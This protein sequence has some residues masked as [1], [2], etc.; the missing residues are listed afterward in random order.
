MSFGEPYHYR[1]NSI[2]IKDVDVVGL[3]VQ[4]DIYENIF[5]GGI[6]GS[7]SMLETDAAKF[8]EDNEIKFIEEITFEFTNSLDQT[9]EFN[10][11]INGYKDNVVI[12]NKRL[13]TLD[14]VSKGVRMNEMVFVNKA[15]R[16]ALPSDI[17][18]D[19][20]KKLNPD[21]DIQNVDIGVPM[22]Y[23]VP[24]IKPLEV[25]KYVND[26]AISTNSKITEND[27][28]DKEAKGTAGFCFWETISGYRFASMD[29]LSK[30]FSF[31]TWQD[32]GTT[33][34]NNSN[35]F[36]EQMRTISEYNFPALGNFQH[37]LRTGT[38]QSKHYSMDIDSGIFSR[39]N[40]DAQGELVKDDMAGS[41][42]GPTRI[43]STIYSSELHEPK[44]KKAQPHV[45]DQTRKSTQQGVAKQ[46]AFTDKHGRI[47]L[48]PQ[49]DMRA[50]DTID[51]KIT[52]ASPNDSPGGFDPNTSG[53]YI[54]HQ[55]GHHILNNGRAYTKLAIL[56]SID[57]DTEADT[58]EFGAV[59]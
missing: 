49:F 43:F 14:F 22:T 28:R 57:Q 46:N 40:Y 50:G 51:I 39:I 11:F 36:D 52:K 29:S 37:K 20:A 27:D 17:A 8:I 41:V 26:N 1:I 58:L 31:N 48:P 54:I 12:G 13:Y 45:W 3:Y 59:Q 23:L 47:T 10:G 32:Y 53:T 19:M 7:V 5:L 21:A 44:C 35:S 55:V 6:T 38:L 34:A 24:N 30:G 33:L 42:S 25:M 18:I 2:R 15:Y 4:V 9:L 16:N 56:R